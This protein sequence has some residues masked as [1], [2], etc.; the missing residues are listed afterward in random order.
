VAALSATQFVCNIF[1]ARW[2]CGVRA[3]KRV[4]VATALVVAGCVLLVVF[5]NHDSPVLT[6]DELLSFYAS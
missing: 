1:F 6:V 4:L 2:I 3:T 5:G